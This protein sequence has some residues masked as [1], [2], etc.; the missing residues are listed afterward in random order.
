M[1]SEMKA[2][3]IIAR[4]TLVLAVCLPGW[5]WASPTSMDPPLQAAPPAAAGWGEPLNSGD[6]DRYRGG[7]EGNDLTYVKNVMLPNGTVTGNAAANIRS[8]DNIIRDGAFT[9]ASGLPMV[10]QNSGSNVLIQNATIVN[11]QLK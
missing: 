10:I 7:A 6:L 8:G 5:S 3:I 9:N 2:I 1:E 11:V 4:T